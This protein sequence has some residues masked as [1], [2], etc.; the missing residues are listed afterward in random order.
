M[1]DA[2]D[3]LEWAATRE[4]GDCVTVTDRT[5]RYR[6]TAPRAVILR[7]VARIIQQFGGTARGQ[8]LARLIERLSAGE[9]GNVAGVLASVER[10]GEWL[11][12]AEPPRRTG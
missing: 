7:V 12:R 5:F 10:N 8:D 4:W 1:A 6:P 11:F 3:A 9:G 2:D